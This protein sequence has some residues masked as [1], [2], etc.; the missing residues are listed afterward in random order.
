MKRKIWRVVLK[1]MRESMSVMRKTLRMSERE[2]EI[3]SS[4]KAAPVL[5][6]DKINEIMWN[7][8]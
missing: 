1:A 4:D 5:S 8:M 7:L 6:D 3:I 2:L